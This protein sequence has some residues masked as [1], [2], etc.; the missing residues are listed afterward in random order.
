[1]I[2]QN[3]KTI[4]KR[5]W[6]GLKRCRWLKSSHHSF[7][8]DITRAWAWSCVYTFRFHC[9]RIGLPKTPFLGVHKGCSAKIPPSVGF[10]PQNY[11]PT[12]KCEFESKNVNFWAFRKNPPQKLS[13]PQKYPP[14]PKIKSV[15]SSPKVWIPGGYFCGTPFIYSMLFA[16]NRGGDF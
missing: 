2:K 7:Q 8:T 5:F 11:P 9:G 15:N 4:E 10:V 3:R 6:V 14:G 13:V 12:E 1:M 16:W